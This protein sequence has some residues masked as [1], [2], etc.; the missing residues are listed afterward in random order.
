M[1]FYFLVPPKGFNLPPLSPGSVGSNISPYA[2][3]TSSWGLP[4]NIIPS[5]PVGPSEGIGLTVGLPTRDP[6]VPWGRGNTN[7]EKGAIV[8]QR[9]QDISS[10]L[11]PNFTPELLGKYKMHFPFEICLEVNSV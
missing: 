7:R 3:Y 9:L 2:Q 4:R 10:Y 11:D 8:P 1:T 6:I 5:T